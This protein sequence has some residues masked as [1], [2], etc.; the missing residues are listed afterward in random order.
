MSDVAIDLRSKKCKPCA[1]GEQPLEAAE[2]QRLLGALDGWSHRDGTISKTFHFPS[3]CHTMAFV[4]A[5]AWI[6]QREDHHPD[7]AVGYDQ[8]RVDY[9]THSIRGLSENDFICAA[10]MDALFA[11]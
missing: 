7:L 2:I 5:S 3:Y 9:R 1:A 8:C 4:N 10:K 11:L 6:S